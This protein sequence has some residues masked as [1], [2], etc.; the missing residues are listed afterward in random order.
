MELLVQIIFLIAILKYCLKAS[1]AGGFKTM[2]L[3]A[4]GVGLWAML[5]YPVVIRQPVTIIEQL[6]TDRHVVMD[7]AVWTTFEALA[8]M[9]LGVE[10]LDNYFA[11][12][13]QRK[14]VWFILKVLPG[15]LAPLG[16]LYFELM[17][18]KEVILD[19]FA[20]TASLYAVMVTAL[21]A[22]LAWGLK[23][24]VEGESLKLELKVLLNMLIL[25]IGLLIN[26][27]VA[28]YN[29]SSAASHTDWRA[30]CLI[31]L[32]STMLIL[33]GYFTRNWNMKQIFNSSKRWIK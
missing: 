21:V 11:P 7:G 16:V 22:M 12:K 4:L 1:L 20:L 9:L 10:L 33:I 3:Y 24:W 13:A 27:A 14:K 8:G 25:L 5:W 6:L 30:L 31:V 17:F 23:H 29:T 19:N 32:G 15:V 26:S 18:F 2:L 28:D